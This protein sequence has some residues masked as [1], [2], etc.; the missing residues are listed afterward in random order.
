MNLDQ[1]LKVSFYAVIDGHGGDWCAQYLQKEMIP[2]LL[3]SMRSEI[4]DSDMENASM[5]ITQLL[6]NT[7][8]RM[9][10]TIDKDFF[11]RNKEASK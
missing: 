1:L 5:P 10:K 8:Y 3:K 7:F 11:D 6:K 2:C 9:Y 4:Y